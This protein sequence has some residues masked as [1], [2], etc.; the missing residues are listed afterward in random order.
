MMQ[1][2]STRTAVVV[3]AIVA[4]SMLLFSFKA[5][6]ATKATIMRSF[7]PL[8]AKYGV[9]RVDSLEGAYSALL[10]AGLPSGK[11]K[12]S[13]AQ[14]MLETGMFGSSS[15]IDTEL[16]NYSGIMW[17][18]KPAVQKNASKGIPFPK[19]EGN[20]FYA[21]FQTPKDWAVDYLRILNRAPGYPLSAASPADFAARLKKNGYYT[22]SEAAY[23]K[24][25]AYYNNLLT[26]LGI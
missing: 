24:N 17:I 10:D 19:R 12:L 22:S 18:N 7:N 20:Y 26:S 15:H 1:S 2:R 9:S 23:A 6:G 14:V 16:N 21:R 3:V 8:I 25:L 5:K 13:L 4:A 11:M